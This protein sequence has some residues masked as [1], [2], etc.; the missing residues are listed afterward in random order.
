MRPEADI[1]ILIIIPVLLIGQETHKEN[2][3]RKNKSGLGS[4][5]KC[6]LEAERMLRMR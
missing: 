5:S 6:T 2:M 3:H 4:D 1:M